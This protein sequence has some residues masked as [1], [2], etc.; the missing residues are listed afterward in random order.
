MT[1]VVDR[2]W[3]KKARIRYCVHVWVE[4]ARSHWVAFGVVHVRVAD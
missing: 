1:A 2:S 4:H 3:T